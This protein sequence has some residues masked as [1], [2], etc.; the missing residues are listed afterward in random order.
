M[1]KYIPITYYK[2][3]TLLEIHVLKHTIISFDANAHSYCQG[4][5][6][7]DWELSLAGE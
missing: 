6:S 3:E 2:D 7:V 5:G 4:D 1:S